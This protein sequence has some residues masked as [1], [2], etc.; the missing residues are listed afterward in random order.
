MLLCINFSYSQRWKDLRIEA[1]LYENK[2]GLLEPLFLNFTLANNSKEVI[3]DIN[4]L[5]SG[6]YLSFKSTTDHNW[7]ELEYYK[8]VTSDWGDSRKFDFVAEGKSQKEYHIL[9][10]R[11]SKNSVSAIK[12]IPPAH[13]DACQKFSDKLFKKGKYLLRLTYFPYEIEKDSLFTKD[14]IYKCEKCIEKIIPFEV[15]AYTKP[16]NIAA[17]NWL[18]NKQESNLCY[19]ID[20]RNFWYPTYSNEEIITYLEEFISLFPTS[21][22]VPYAAHKAIQVSNYLSMWEKTEEGK[23]KQL[24]IMLKYVR[25]IEQYTNLPHQFLIGAAA[26]KKLESRITELKQIINQ[27]K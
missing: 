16:E 4:Y 12:N 2:I 14:G 26:S 25:L 6:L 1:E 11:S 21:K 15:V 13:I 22:F 3:K 24:S 5:I 19:K 8:M 20:P 23:I 18:K 7:E 27:K 17:Y 9:F 10:P